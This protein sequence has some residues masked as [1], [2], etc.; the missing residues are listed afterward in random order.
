MSQQ[1]IH[2]GWTHHTDPTQIHETSADLLRGLVWTTCLV[3]SDEL[4]S[5]VGNAAEMC[6]KKIPNIGPRSPK[7]GNACLQAL[8]EMNQLA[9]VAQISRLKTRA[10]HASI[11]KQLAKALDRA[12]EKLGITEADLEEIAVPKFGFEAVGYYEE[13]LGDYTA[14]LAVLPKG[15]TQLLWV[16]SDGNTQ[17]TVPAAIKQTHGEQLKALK[18]KAKEIEKFLPAQ[19]NRIEQLFLQKRS[20]KLC[21]FRER[22]LDHP[23]VGVLA[24]RVIWRFKARDRSADGV[25]YQGKLVDSQGRELD[26]IDDETEVMIWHPMYSEA[27]EVLRWREWL[28]LHE[29]CQPLKQAHREIY[30]LTD[31]ERG[32]G[33]YSNRFAAHIIRQHQFAALCRERG[34]RYSLEGQWDS[35]NTPYLELPEWGLRAEYWVEAIE[36]GNVS[37][38]GIYLFMST[39]QLRFC[40]LANSQPVALVDV[41]DRVFSEVM[42]DVDLFVGVTSIGND[43]DGLEDMTTESYRDYWQQYA[44]GDLSQTA[45]T[46]KEVLQRLVPR[47]KIA[48]RCSFADKF[49]VV[50]GDLRTYKIHLGSGNV[51][52]SP[53]QRHL[54]IVPQRSAGRQRTDN[55]FLPFDGDHLL[56]VIL[57]KAFLLAEDASIKDDSILSQIRR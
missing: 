42:R 8:A 48:D 34:W 18:H 52:A 23:L 27:D 11:R 1:I 41:P 25:W 28:E 10:K 31:A 51:L 19:R 9:A 47:L 37:P 35:A 38:V 5:A 20:W 40:R 57:S 33:T 49:L 50:R 26:W 13:R 17:K 14:Q 55:L 45:Q 21:D 12:A 39:D 24:R 7:I 4:I 22:Y 44:F 29:I 2:G 54:C 46:R 3:S 15:S 30:I 6:F 16:K 56:S 53:D 36:A 32:T 43:P